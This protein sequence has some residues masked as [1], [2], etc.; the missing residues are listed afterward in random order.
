MPLERFDVA[1]LVLTAKTTGR[2][3]RD[4]MCAQRGDGQL[5]EADGV[6][7]TRHEHRHDG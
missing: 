4:E 1:T 2:A 5:H 6:E 7:A 3:D